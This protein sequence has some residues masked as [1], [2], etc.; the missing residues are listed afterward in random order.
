MR[1]GMRCAQ[2]CAQPLSD[3]DSATDSRFS[4]L[5]SAPHTYIVGRVNQVKLQ[6]LLASRPLASLNGGARE[7]GSKKVS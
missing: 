4:I 7:R 1:R 2:Q 3:C 5:G 6:R